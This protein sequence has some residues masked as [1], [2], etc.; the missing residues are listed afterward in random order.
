MSGS[1]QA[2]QDSKSS[3]RRFVSVP[4]A[5]AIGTI[6]VGL[7]LWEVLSQFGYA[8]L[9]VIFPS[10]SLIGSALVELL[11]SGEFYSHF[12]VTAQ[13]VGIALGL[14]AAIGIGG[15]TI[16]GSNRY[17]AEGVEPVIYYFSTVPKIILYPLFIAALGAASMDS[18]VA[19]GF[20]SAIF[21]I[22]VNAIT[23]A[24]GVRQDLVKVARVYRAKPWETFAKVY[25]PSML[26]HLVNGLRLGTGVAI[27][28]V[29][30]GELF[31]SQAGL[32]NR[33]AFY[34]AN[35]LTDFMYA[36]LIVIFGVALAINL[37]LLALQNELARRGYG[38]V[39][40]SEEGFGF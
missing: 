6:V 31:A 36:A 34:F 17:L 11:S 3:R 30:L 38:S 7:V 12:W 22:T 1:I 26:T 35:L 2:G 40:D 16:V 32:G 29:L 25:V 39:G 28:G 37:G 15:G 20:F 19:I 13:E 9:D 4:R 14:A 18:K 24:L 8:K 5:I 10:L 23:G 21:P 33:I 27:I